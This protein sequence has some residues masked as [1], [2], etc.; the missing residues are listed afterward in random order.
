MKGHSLSLVKFPLMA[1]NDLGGQKINIGVQAGDVFQPSV[2]SGIKSKLVKYFAN[3]GYIFASVY[4][5]KPDMDT[6]RVDMVFK[7]TMNAPVF[8]RRINLAGDVVTSDE[9]MRR[10]LMVH[11]AKVTLCDLLESRR[12]LANLGFLQHQDYTKNPGYFS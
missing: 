2:N 5:V 10:V 3:Q 9:V 12:R 11:E 7:Y 4:A 8:V 6:Q 1:H